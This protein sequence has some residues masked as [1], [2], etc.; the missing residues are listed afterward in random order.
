VA[1][2]VINQL[3]VGFYHASVPNTTKLD[4]TLAFAIFAR[5]ENK[6]YASIYP[7]RN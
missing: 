7:P 2:L 4:T 3:V 5:E 6:G 1:E